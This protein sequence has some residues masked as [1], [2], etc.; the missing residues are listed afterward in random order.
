VKINTKNQAA[1]HSRFLY[2]QELFEAHGGKTDVA[3]TIN[4][5]TLYWK[6]FMERMRLRPGAKEFLYRLKRDNIKIC[7]ITDLTAKIQ[8]EK[9]LRLKIGPYIN[10]IVSSE[11]AGVEKPARKIFQI[12]LKKL[13]CRPNEAAMVGDDVDRDSAGAKLL[14][15]K[16]F[17]I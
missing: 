7:V 4:F 17:S 11:G 12:A 1:S 16:T 14:G 6:T 5:E 15:I 9:I 13:N 2:F 3:R 10:F 8:F